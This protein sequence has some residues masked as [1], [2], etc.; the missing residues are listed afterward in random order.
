VLTDGNGVP[1]V[2]K[3]TAANRHDV[4][5]ILDLVNEVPAISGVR[6]APRY[7]FDE[8]YA[9]RGYDSEPVRDALR[10]VGIKPH[11]ARRNTDNGSGLGVYRWV[12]ER[13]LSWLHQFRRLR[14]R[15]E[16]RLDIHQAFL[17]IGCVLICHRILENALC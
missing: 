6:G 2:A 1:V 5:Q 13:T 16:R 4:T 8:L 17:M 10:E 11:I 9:D 3:T 15:Y 7:R 14:I 12:V